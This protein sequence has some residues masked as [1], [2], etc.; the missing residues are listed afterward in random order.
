VTPSDLL[1]AAADRVRDLAAQA[2]PGPWRQHDGW[3]PGTLGVV[4]SVLS[5]EDNDTQVRA[6]L[7]TFEDEPN[8]DARNVRA[9]AA[10]VAAMSPEVAPHLEA[11]LRHAAVMFEVSKR[12]AETWHR[13]NEEAYVSDSDHE[14]LAFARVILGVGLAGETP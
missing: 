8:S 6:L 2:T 5:G 13:V 10:W 4:A 9:D 12:R 7:P 14:A 3:W 1:S 11:W